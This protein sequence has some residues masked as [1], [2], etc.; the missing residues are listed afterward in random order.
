VLDKCGHHPEIEQADEFVRVV[1][2]FLGA[3]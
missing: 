3:A 2:E 1:H